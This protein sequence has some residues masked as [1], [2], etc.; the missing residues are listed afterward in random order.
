LVL[1]M[2]SPAVVGQVVAG[3]ELPIERVVFLAGRR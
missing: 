3:L 2:K 1:L